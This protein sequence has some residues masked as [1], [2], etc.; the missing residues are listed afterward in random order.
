MAAEAAEQVAVEERTW[1]DRVYAAVPLATVFIWL[2]ALYAWQSWHHSSPWLFTDE[3][4]LTQLSRSIA[5]T[6]HAARRGQ[7]HFFETLYTYLTAP[8]W[9]LSSTAQAYDVVRYIGVFTMTAV[10][11]PTYFLARTIVRTPAALFAAA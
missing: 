11:F 2:V 4:E 8:A 6:G 10:V 9:W 1:L 7:P 5:D 3:L